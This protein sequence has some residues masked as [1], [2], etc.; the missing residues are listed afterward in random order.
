MNTVKSAFEAELGVEDSEPF[1]LEKQEQEN[2][3]PYIPNLMPEN[4][5]LT[6]KQ[7]TQDT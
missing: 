6:Q 1:I 4:I 2:N 5:K 7:N 3:Q